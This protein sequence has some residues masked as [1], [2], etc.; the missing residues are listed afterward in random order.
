MKVQGVLFLLWF[1]VVG[2]W[3]LNQFKYSHLRAEQKKKVE[4]GSST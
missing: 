1:V 3:I 4:D 2:I